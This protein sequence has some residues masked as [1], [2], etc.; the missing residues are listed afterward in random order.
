[1]FF[2][3]PTTHG[4]LYHIRIQLVPLEEE[5]RSVP[6]EDQEPREQRVARF[7]ESS[8]PGEDGLPQTAHDPNRNI[9]SPPPRRERTRSHALTR[10]PKD[11]ASLDPAT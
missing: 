8:P 10:C 9:G 6:E 4:P 7:G 3:A 1:M 5:G 2:V 11:T